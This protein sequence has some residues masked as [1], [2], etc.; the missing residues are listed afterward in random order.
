MAD[1]SELELRIIE[2]ENKLKELASEP[3]PVDLT[4]AEVAAYNKVVK[5]I[6]ILRC[7]RTCGRNCV[8]SCIAAADEPGLGT[9]AIYYCS[10][11]CG[12]GCGRSC[13]CS[14]SCIVVA[15]AGEGLMGPTAMA[16]R[17]CSYCYAARGCSRACYALAAC[18]C[19]GCM[20]GAAQPGPKGR[21]GVG[22]FANL[23]E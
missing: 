1:E 17:G 5:A 16:C 23:G 6:P 15:D 10:R 9:E 19:G 21:G 3:D 7:G 8:S 14:C 4:A 12:R 11:G 18:E 22:R 2:L 13:S 20:P